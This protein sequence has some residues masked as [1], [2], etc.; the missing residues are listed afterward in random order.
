MENTEDIDNNEYI[1]ILSQPNVNFIRALKQI[2]KKEITPFKN[3]IY[4]ADDS[5]RKLPSIDLHE[6]PRRGS[7]SNLYRYKRENKPSYF[8]K[9]IN[10]A[11]KLGDE[12]DGRDI[13]YYETNKILE[14][15]KKIE[16]NKKLAKLL[17]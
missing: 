9:K 5:S 12:W 2:R 1:E 11:K 17:L 15:N 3:I 16:A 4:T 8:I 6:A 13:R 14:A 10:D 7:D